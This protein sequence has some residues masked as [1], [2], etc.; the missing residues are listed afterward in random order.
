M[1]MIVLEADLAKVKAELGAEIQ[2]VEREDRTGERREV[3][4][5]IDPS[6]FRFVKKTFKKQTNDGGAVEVLTLVVHSQGDSN[7]D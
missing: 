2:K 3:V 1:K 7:I 4:I 5:L 6:N